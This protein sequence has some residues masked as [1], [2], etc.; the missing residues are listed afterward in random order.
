M[1]TVLHKAARFGAGSVSLSE[2]TSPQCG[3]C[4]VDSGD[5]SIGSGTGS[6]NRTVAAAAL[7]HCP[8]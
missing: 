6:S 8:L 7:S 4:L 3:P 2:I 5:S 1:A